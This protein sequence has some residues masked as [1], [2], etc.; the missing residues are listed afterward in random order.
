MKYKL[1]ISTVLVLFLAIVPNAFAS[2]NWY[3]DGVHGNDGNDCMSF[4]LAC[5]T[6]GHAITLA[7]SGDSILVA[8]AT[9]PEI[10]PS[11]LT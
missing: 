1:V 7:S 8:S 4:H 3:V 6:I 10:L 11:A 2:S 5:K 9:Y